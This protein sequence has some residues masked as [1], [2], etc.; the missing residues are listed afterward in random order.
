MNVSTYRRIRLIS[1]LVLFI[2]VS[3]H[4]INLAW[5]LVSLEALDIG[6][7]VFVAVWRSIPGTII[8]YGALFTHMSLVLW[9]LYQRRTL[10]L[11]PRE[12]LQILLGLA[13]P[14]LLIEH[15]LG[16]R[17]LFEIFDVTDNYIYEVLVLWVFAP[18]KGIL[19]VIVLTVAWL[20]GCIGLHYWLKLRP[21]YPEWSLTLYALAILVPTTAAFGF[22]TVGREI[23]LLAQDPF[24]LEDVYVATNFPE[25][26]AVIWVGMWKHIA[27]YAMAGLLAAIMAARYVR[28]LI[29]ARQGVIRLTYPGNR[30]VQIYK[31]ITVLES[32]R[33]NGIP[34]AAVCGGRGRCSTCR[35]RVGEGREHLQPASADEIKVLQRVGAP[36]HVRLACQLRPSHDLSVVPLLPASVGT[37]AAYRKPSYF[38]GSEKE[39]AILFADIRSF[40]KF[41]ENK[42]PYDVVFVLNRYF[43]SMGQAVIS[44]G[45]ELDKFIGDGVMA[46]FGA[47]TEPEEGCRRALTAAKRMG[48]ALDE[49]NETLKD[50][51]AE[52]LRIGIGIHLGS[53]IVGEMGFAEATSFTA[54]GDAVNTASRLETATKVFQC[55]LIVSTEVPERAGVD[56]SAHPIEE[57]TVR[58]RSQP[59]LVHTIKQ[60]GDLPTLAIQ[61]APAK[62]RRRR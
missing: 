41:S 19:Q 55:Q 54:I 20:H 1:G 31:P 32:S 62:R 17:G 39:V 51:L 43:R 34:H 42:L 36:Q 30:V 8:L 6:R 61:G 47:D 38:Q 13:I 27:W 50:D 10:R 4:L 16:T 3:S 49:L 21:W 15:V 25:E 11:R 33:E 28:L 52:P 22:V 2:Y 5:G 18:E 35:V 53:V 29:E 40:T 60:A 7:D 12:G 24:W 37:Q 56:L 44:S 9:T 59:I 26:A 57:I 45:G 46:L 14:P 58:G 48:E 23:S